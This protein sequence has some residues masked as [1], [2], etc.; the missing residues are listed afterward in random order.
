MTTSLLAPGNAA[1]AT[2]DIDVAAGAMVTVGLYSAAEAALPPGVH[3]PI[4]QLTPGAPN[5]LGALDN[6]VRS[7]SLSGPCTYRVSRPEYV[8][9]AFGVFRSDV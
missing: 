2:V 4:Q 6:S 3:F 1:G 5:H 8:G 7:I 9:P